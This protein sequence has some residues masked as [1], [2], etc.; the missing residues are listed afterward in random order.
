MTID[1]WCNEIYN[2]KISK[3]PEMNINP[4][5]EAK[6]IQPQESSLV[7]NPNATP[8]PDR[9]EEDEYWKQLE[10]LEHYWQPGF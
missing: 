7:A 8:V 5:V 1:K 10:Q 9:G 2:N 4:T 3:E 6:P